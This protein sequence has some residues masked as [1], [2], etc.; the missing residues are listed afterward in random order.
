MEN[1]E[2]LDGILFEE[3]NSGRVGF[4]RRLG[5]YL[6]DF[7]AIMIFGTFV[8]M[9]FGEELTIIFFS[10]QIDEFERSAAQFESLGLGDYMEGWLN[11]IAGVSVTGL[12]LIVMEG[13]MGQSIGKI[14]LKIINTNVDGTKASGGKLWLRSL[15]KYGA[16]I[17]SLVGGMVGIAFL[18][19]IGSFWS[20]VIFVGFFF[21]IG[22]KKQTIHDMIAKTVVSYKH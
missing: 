21:A 15:L 16:S 1:Q 18:G 22:D 20:L 12:I 11:I 13:V 17:L 3:T 8:G 5:A 9:F 6:L 2:E 14:L 4:G 10:D 7:L 19:T